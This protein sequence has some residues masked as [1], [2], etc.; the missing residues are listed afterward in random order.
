MKK[1]DI[2]LVVSAFILIASCFCLLIYRNGAAERK[3]VFSLKEI[4]GN[5]SVSAT[6]RSINNWNTVENTKFKGV[7]LA[8]LLAQAGVSDGSASVKI[9][10]PDG[11]FWPPVGKKLRLSDLRK[12]NTKGL[13]PII[14]YE[15]AG[16]AL[17][18]EP[19]GTGP[20]RL[21]IPQYKPGEVNKPSW[22]S[23]L[24]LIEV[25]P[26]PKGVKRLS[27]KKVSMD[28]LW[29]YG[30]VPKRY[31]FSIWFPIAL[32]AAGL[33]LAVI[34]ALS[35]RKGSEKENKNKGV[36][37]FL[38]LVMGSMILSPL[39]LQA[40]GSNQVVFSKGELQSMPSFTGHY[41]FL[42]QLP[43]YTYYEEDY[44]G[45]LLSY[46]LGTKLSLLPNAT[47][48]VVRARDGYT[49]TL[50]PSQM[51]KTYPGDLK[52]IIA[53]SKGGKPLVGDEGPLRLIVPQENPGTRE[54]GGDAN[55]PLCGRMIYAVEVQP[56]P[57]GV[58]PP[59]ASAIPDGSLAIY[60]AVSTPTPQTQSEQAPSGNNPQAQ[61]TPAP[62]AAATPADQAPGG[63]PAVVADISSL[64]PEFICFCL[65][66]RVAL[67][68][69]VRKLPK[70]VTD[71]FV[72]AFCLVVQ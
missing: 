47:S 31:P 53:Y 50:S 17:D 49:A 8:G 13:V 24:R 45:V 58:S 29:I 11:Y 28:E 33:L 69:F 67:S 42:K 30:N 59:A 14:A 54:Q 65:A 19:Q 3:H 62:A 39:G 25:G 68:P 52:V 18:P 1:R 9:I 60:G 55:T 6:Y 20:L 36:A 61:S 48:I 51:N 27:A 4:M 21:V 41:T 12:R 22:V 46:L 35:P 7:P 38:L 32:G 71:L 10:A 26:L 56:L 2:L 5:E 57:S 64:K 16:R 66:T 37:V 15:C 23:N 63:T 43:P 70:G 72:I 44:T 40:Q 34:G